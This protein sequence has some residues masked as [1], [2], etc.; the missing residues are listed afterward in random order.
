MSQ[1]E[2]SGVEGGYPLPDNWYDSG[3]A[4]A[5][6]KY[7]PQFKNETVSSLNFYYNDAAKSWAYGLANSQNKTTSM[8]VK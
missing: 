3:E 7:L 4:I 5:A 8:W 2:V 1:K 6:L